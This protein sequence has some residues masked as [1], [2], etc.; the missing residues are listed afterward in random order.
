MTQPVYYVE[1]NSPDLNAS[2]QFFAEVFGW[3][4]QPFAAPE[5]LVAAAG[6]TAGIDAALMPSRDG[7]ARTVPVIR[8]DALDDAI[9]GVRTHGGTVVVEPFTI[10]GMGRAC[11]VL[12]PAGVLLGV[13]EYDFDARP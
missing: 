12:D 7:Q 4:P 10:T 8:V 9:E 5:Y 6:D 2:R 1:I 11:Y 3:D 13:H